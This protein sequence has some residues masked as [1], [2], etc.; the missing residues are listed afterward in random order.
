M[1]V[2]DDCGSRNL[3]KYGKYDNKQKWHCCDCGLTSIY[4]RARKRRKINNEVTKQ[5]NEVRLS[6]NEGQKG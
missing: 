5:D 3:V 1:P 4:A 2:C 6:S